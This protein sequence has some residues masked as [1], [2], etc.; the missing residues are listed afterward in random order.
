MLTALLL[1]RGDLIPRFEVALLIARTAILGRL[2]LI[3]R[4]RFRSYLFALYV[5]QPGAVPIH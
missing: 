1:F 5:P 2:D 4:K 3:L